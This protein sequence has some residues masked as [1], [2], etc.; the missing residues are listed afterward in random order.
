MLA[1]CLGAG[2]NGAF[3]AP[4]DIPLHQ[5]PIGPQILMALNP[6]VLND[7]LQRLVYIFDIHNI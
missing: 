2:K 4:L 1:I 6:S 5:L 3:F 7:N